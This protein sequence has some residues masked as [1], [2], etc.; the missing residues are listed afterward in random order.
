MTNNVLCHQTAKYACRVNNE[1]T[2]ACV[3]TGYKQL[4]QFNKAR[5]NDE[6][7]R[8]HTSLLVEP[9]AER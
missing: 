6:I 2:E 1:I 9:E 4:K 5:K 3:A 7:N 8:E